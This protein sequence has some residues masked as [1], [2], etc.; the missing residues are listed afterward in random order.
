MSRLS[1]HNIMS[2]LFS[3]AIGWEWADRNPIT[4]VRQSAKRLR[5]PDVLTPLKITALL[6][7]MPEPL[8]A[9]AELDA[10]TGLR[11]GELIGL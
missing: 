11:L 4:D 7:K 6:A 10:S 5:T 9:A 2:A 3:H 1:Q 8:R